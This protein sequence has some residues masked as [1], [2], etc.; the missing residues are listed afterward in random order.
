LIEGKGV[1]VHRQEANTIDTLLSKR[2]L[3][4]EAAEALLKV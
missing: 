1:P 3:P 2:D 4:M